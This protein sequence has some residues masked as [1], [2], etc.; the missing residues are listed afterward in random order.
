[1]EASGKRRTMELRAGNG[2]AMKRLLDDW[3]RKLIVLSKS[4][5]DIISCLLLD[6]TIA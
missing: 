4:K 2:E 1:M 3:G 5:K 6:K